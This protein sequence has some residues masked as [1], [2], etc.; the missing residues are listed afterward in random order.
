MKTNTKPLLPL[1]NSPSLPYSSQASLSEVSKLSTSPRKPKSLS[2]SATPIPPLP[3]SRISQSLAVNSCP[4]STPYTG[5]ASHSPH[6]TKRYHV[7]EE[8]AKPQTYLYFAYGSNLARSTFLDRRGIRPLSVLPVLVPTLSLTFD[9][10]GIPYSEPCF[11]NVRY[12]DPQQRKKRPS[13]STPTKDGPSSQK[14]LLRE[15]E[16]PDRESKWSKPLIGLVY[17]VTASDYAHILATEGAGT[18]YQDVLVPVYAF[19][20]KHDIASDPVPEEP[21]TPAFLVHTLLFP[22][23]AP[24][25][26]SSSLCKISIPSRPQ[27]SQINLG[28]PNWDKPISR[29]NRDYAQPSERYINLIRTGA[30][31]A[32]LPAEYRAYLEGVQSYTITDEKQKMGGELFTGIWGPVILLLLWLMRTLG[33]G[34]GEDGGRNGDGGNEDGGNGDGKAP[35]WLLKLSRVVFWAMW[36]SYDGLFKPMFGDGERTVEGGKAGDGDG[37]GDGDR[38]GD[39]DG[40]INEKRGLLNAHNNFMKHRKE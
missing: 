27:V 20:E 30:V 35:A 33:E 31:E 4:S 3:Q 1:H 29:P 32:N 34:K 10:P 13:A 40:G 6:R 19:P 2:P 21:S 36:M 15:E 17:E 16:E 5:R 7:H 39:R 24:S 11:A 14:A 9:L 37:D 38:G 22:W 25:S 23:E 12:R 18:A 28:N 26:S 8:L